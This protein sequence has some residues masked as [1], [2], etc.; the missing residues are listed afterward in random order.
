[1][2]IF[3][4]QKGTSLKYRLLSV[5]GCFCL[6]FFSAAGRVEPGQISKS[7]LLG[8]FNYRNEASFKRLEPWFA[9]KDVYLHTEAYQAFKKMHAAAMKEGIRLVVVSGT[10]SFYDQKI[11]WEHKWNSSRFAGASN[12]PDRAKSILRYSSVP[13]TSRHHWGTDMDL[14]SL[15]SAY[16]KSA[17]GIKMYTWMTRN[18]HKFGFYQP[19][20]ADRSSGYQ[21]EKWHW[22]YVPLSKNY[23]EAYQRRIAPGDI[24]GFRGDAAC[25][26]IDVITNWVLSVNSDCKPTM[27]AQR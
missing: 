12:G 11:I 23:L 7:F 8:K 17:Q 15:S 20:N 18:A 1:M 25:R 6:V 5:L 3:K 22:S 14:N 2:P 16:Y 10:R 27:Q 13:G 4:E 9:A 19:F 26:D 21:E 24:S